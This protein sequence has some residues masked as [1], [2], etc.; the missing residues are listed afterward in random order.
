MGILWTIYFSSEAALNVLGLGL[1]LPLL[2]LFSLVPAMASALTVT[3]LKWMLIGRYRPRFEPLWSHFVRGPSS[4]Q[5]THEN[6]N[7]P[8]LLRFLV[9]TPLIRPMLRLLGV[10]LGHNVLLL[11]TWMSEFD[12]TEVEDDCAMN[13]GV[14]LQTHLF[15]DR[16]MKMSHVHIGRSCTIGKRTVV[17]YDSEMKTGAR[18]GNLSLLMKGETLAEGSEWEGSPAQSMTPIDAVPS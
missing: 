9:G 16:V 13:A 10:K 1:S 14:S 4:S 12:L 2:P 7:V 5:D 8:F 18:L 17:L 6:V 3:A 11:T 15:E